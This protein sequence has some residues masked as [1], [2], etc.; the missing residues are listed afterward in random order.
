ME[1]FHIFKLCGEGA[2][3]KV[4]RAI[5]MDPLNVTVM[6]YDDEEDEEQLVTLFVLSDIKY[7][8]NFAMTYIQTILI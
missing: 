8:D 7:A 4:Y 6:P 5:T 1:C 2:Y 3:A